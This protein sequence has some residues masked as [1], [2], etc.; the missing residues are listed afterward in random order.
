MTAFGGT[1][2]SPSASPPA[3]FSTGDFYGNFIQVIVVLAVVIGLIVLT[4]RFLATRNKRWSG[5]RSLRVHAGLAL[6]QNKSL[7]II[8]IGDAVYIVGVGDNISVLD[9]IEDQ[10]RIDALISSL[11]TKPSASAGAV[12]SAVAKTL[13]RVRNRGRG[14][15]EAESWETNEAFRDLLNQKLK[16][17]GSRK[18]RLKDWMEEDQ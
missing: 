1:I 11:E 4:I 9:K 16:G 5:D 6:G 18:D 10:E 2:D 8:E 13:A 17:I 3:E 7:Q 15:P 14:A 12:V